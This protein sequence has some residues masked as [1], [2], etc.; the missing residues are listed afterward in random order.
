[1]AIGE[2]GNAPPLAG[3]GSPA[4]TTPMY[5]MYEMAQASLN[6]ARAVSDATKDPVS[7]SAEPLVAHQVRQIGRRGLRIVRAHYAPLRQAGMGLDETEV[8]GIRTP[9]SEER[10]GKAFCRLL[11]STASSPARCAA[12]S[13]RVLIVAR[14]PVTTRRCCAAPSRRSCRRISLHHRL[15]RTRAW[16]RSPKAAS[17]STTTST[18]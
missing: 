10:L 16:C 18:T 17:I 7:E 4:L 12:R 14:C 11:H 3:K 13:P 8:N 15:D 5:W 2:F 6:P 9:S 1:M